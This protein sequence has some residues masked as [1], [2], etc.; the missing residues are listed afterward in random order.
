VIAKD[1]QFLQL[2]LYL[3]DFVVP[4]SFNWRWGMVQRSISRIL[5]C[6]LKRDHMSML[7]FIIKN[8]EQRHFI[9]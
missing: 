7:L 4:H 5:C 1:L 2:L 6:F 9:N 8:S 3:L